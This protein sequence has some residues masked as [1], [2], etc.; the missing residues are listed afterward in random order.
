VG[1]AGSKQRPCLRP[2]LTHPA[3][4]QRPLSTCRPADGRRGDSTAAVGRGQAAA[5]PSEPRY[6]PTVGG[7]AHFAAHSGSELS[8]LRG[9][10]LP[11]DS[12][13]RIHRTSARV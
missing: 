12:A 1:F 13:S 8:E 4:T 6:G 10:P 5:R 3:R 9:T 2:F 7:A 11:M